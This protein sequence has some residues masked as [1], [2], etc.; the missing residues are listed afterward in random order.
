MAVWDKL[1]KINADELKKD[2]AEAKDGGNFEELPAGKYEVTIE[3][4]ELKE[5][6]ETHNPMIVITLNVLEGEYK[7]RK[8]WVNLVLLDGKHDGFLMKRAIETLTQLQPSMPVV[9]EDGK[10]FEKLVEDIGNEVTDTD[11]IV[12]VTKKGKYRNHEFLE[13]L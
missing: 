13:A 7:G 9:F 4:F 5:T 10:Q 2:I 6:K 12:R 3:N 1:N 11:Y 8:D